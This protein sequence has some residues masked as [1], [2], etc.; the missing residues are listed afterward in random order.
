VAAKLLA[1]GLDFASRN[2]LCT[3]ISKSAE[4]N[5]VSWR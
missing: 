2:T 5:A 4:T 3:S 1:D